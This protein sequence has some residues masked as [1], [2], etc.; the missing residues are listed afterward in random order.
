MPDNIEA[1]ALLK[2]PE[3]LDSYLAVIKERRDANRRNRL[4]AY[5]QEAVK[6]LRAERNLT[7]EEG[8]TE[9][10][11]E[12]ERFITAF[13]RALALPA[14]PGQQ[15][16]PAVKPQVESQPI[17][18]AEGAAP[19]IHPDEAISLDQSDEQA[20]PEPSLFKTEEP[21]NDSDI[22]PDEPSPRIAMRGLRKARNVQ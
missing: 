18:V 15:P 13:E 8:D 22:A 1:D 17:G 4:Q 19:S 10:A 2:S 3:L 14:L 9:I 16:A 5:W 6:R 11:E 12:L 21:K 20:A 7:V